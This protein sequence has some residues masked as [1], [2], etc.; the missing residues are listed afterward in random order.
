M[1]R[2]DTRYNIYPLTVIQ[3]IFDGKTGTRLDRILAS[4]NSVYLT[5]EGTFAD[6]VNKLDKFIVVRIY[7]YL[8]WC[9]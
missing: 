2:N 4:C 3:A 7:Y 9:N 6:T 5:W 1:W 8:S